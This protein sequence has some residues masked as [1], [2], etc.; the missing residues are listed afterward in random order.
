MAW[1]LLV[2]LEEAA[3]LAGGW[4]M[5]GVCNNEG[6]Y[7]VMERIVDDGYRDYE[8]NTGMG[9]YWHRLIYSQKRLWAPKTIDRRACHP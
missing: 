9:A 2:L 1:K 4:D 8:M 7:E 3:A 5:T 6:T